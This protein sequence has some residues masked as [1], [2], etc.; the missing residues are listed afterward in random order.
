MFHVQGKA[1]IVQ[2]KEPY[3]NLNMVTSRLST[4]SVQ[5]APANNSQAAKREKMK[6][7]KGA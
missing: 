7:R 5:S 2:V 1:S 3:S 4:R 6:V